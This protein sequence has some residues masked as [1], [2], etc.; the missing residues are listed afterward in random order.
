M[1][2][3]AWGPSEI[4]RYMRWQLSLF[5][6]G[7]IKRQHVGGFAYR[8]PTLSNQLIPK[9]F[10]ITSVA[11]SEY[12]IQPPVVDFEI[13]TKKKKKGSKRKPSSD[14][15]DSADEDEDDEDESEEIVDYELQAW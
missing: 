5:K 15:A 4:A 6:E 7:K 13:E 1:A 14:S 12:L 2:H 8:L 3:T 11:K 10:A 9:K